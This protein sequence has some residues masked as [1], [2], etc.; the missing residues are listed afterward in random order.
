MLD[1][2]DEISVGLPAQKLKLISK[3]LNRIL[4]ETTFGYSQE[5]AEQYR[6]DP[7]SLRASQF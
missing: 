7:N 4:T 6:R 3:F 2:G 5:R 1:D